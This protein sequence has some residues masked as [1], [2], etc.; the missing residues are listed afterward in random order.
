MGYQI[1]KFFQDVKSALDSCLLIKG[2]APVKQLEI[3]R[4]FCVLAFLLVT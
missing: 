2:S 3:S 1:V 4:G